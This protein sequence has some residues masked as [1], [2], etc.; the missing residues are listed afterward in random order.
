MN[1]LDCATLYIAPILSLHLSALLVNLPLQ[2]YDHLY[3]VLGD[4]IYD[5][6][7]TEPPCQEYLNI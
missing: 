7:N 1:S 4:L 2:C 3:Q 5:N 6:L